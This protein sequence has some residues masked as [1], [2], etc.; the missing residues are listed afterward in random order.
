MSVSAEIAF[1]SMGRRPFE[2]EMCPGPNAVRATVVKTAY[3]LLI[4]LKDFEPRASL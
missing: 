3:S 4:I 1:L 2:Q